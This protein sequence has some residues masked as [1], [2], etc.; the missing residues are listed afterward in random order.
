MNF[1]VNWLCR[2]YRAMLCA[3]PA[4]FRRRYGGE[5]SQVF[6][7]RCRESARSHSL[8]GFLVASALDWSRSV[9]RERFDTPSPNAGFASVPC[10]SADGVPVFYLGANDTPACAALVQG[11]FLTL[12]VFAALAFALTH[13]GNHRIAF[14]IGAHGAF[15][16]NLPVDYR[17]TIEADRKTEVRVAPE[18]ADAWRK[19]VSS[20]FTEN[21]VLLVLD[22]NRDLVISADEIANAPARLRMLDVNH[23]GKL[24]AEECG[25]ILFRQPQPGAEWP[26]QAARDYMRFHPVLAALDTNHDGEISADEIRNSPAAMK[27]LVKNKDGSLTADELVPY[28]R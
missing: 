2:I 17:S 13:W 3:Y 25:L 18:A 19:F 8:V 9:I 21:L 26:K 5:M 12:V 22:R 11:T 23:D 28:R 6:A 1:L 4:A 14:V 16:S 7:D 15:S 24:D 20:Y 27:K 10:R